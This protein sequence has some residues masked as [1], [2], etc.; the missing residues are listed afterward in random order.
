MSKYNYTIKA[1]TL[2]KFMRDIIKW[3]GAEIV[4]IKINGEHYEVIDDLKNKK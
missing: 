1:S 2:P 3:G 4:D